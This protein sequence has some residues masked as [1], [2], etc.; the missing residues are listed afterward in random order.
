MSYYVTHLTPSTV[1]PDSAVTPPGDWLTLR[2]IGVHESLLQAVIQFSSPSIRV[3]FVHNGAETIK[4]DLNEIE[5][6]Y[7]LNSA[8]GG[9][10]QP[11]F[12][13]CYT[14]PCRW[15]FSIPDPRGWVGGAGN[16]VIQAQG[17]GAGPARQM[18][19]GMLF[20][21]VL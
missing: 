12:T 18:T 4:L 16:L 17:Y 10:T 15:M 1:L 14:N 13:R 8:N 3:R 20:W 7:A 9:A 11:V 21:R 6:D 5:A 19:R 2:T